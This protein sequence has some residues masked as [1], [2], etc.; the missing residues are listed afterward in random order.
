[1]TDK[2]ARLAAG[3][4]QRPSALVLERK[5]SSTKRILVVDDDAALRR[6]CVRILEAAGHIVDSA[7]NAAIGVTLFEHDPYE[8]VVTD[9]VM[10]K[11]D[12]TA[13]IK[14][15]RAGGRAVKIIAMS[16]GS[17][18][19]PADTGLRLGRAY[20]VDAVLYKPF[21]PDE[22]INTIDTL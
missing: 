22:L 20:G 12:G 8:I 18:E 16:G 6:M 15:L 19:L 13:L 5:S 10:P 1:M 17:E 9:I 14:A 3:A 4:G 2:P 11:M 21:R 7:A